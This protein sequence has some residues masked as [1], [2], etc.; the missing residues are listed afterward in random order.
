MSAGQAGNDECGHPDAA[1]EVAVAKRFAVWAGEDESR[2]DEPVEMLAKVRRHEVREGDATTAST[3]FGR[4]ER[5]TIAGRIVD[6]MGNADSTGAR[7][8]RQSWFRRWRRP[9]PI[10][11]RRTSAQGGTAGIQGVTD[12]PHG[13]Q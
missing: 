3:R 10:G 12:C 7:P 6:L 2:R 5:V 8:R 4:P 11:A 1:V 9:G 13:R